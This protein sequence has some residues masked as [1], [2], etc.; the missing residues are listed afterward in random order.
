MDWS[1][2]YSKKNNQKYWFNKKTGESTWV[3]PQELKIHNFRQNKEKDIALLFLTYDNIYFQNIYDDYFNKC[4]VYIH[5]K[6]PEKIIEENRQYIISNIV[7]TEWGKIGIVNA[8]IELLKASY[9]NENNKWFI[10]LSQDTF[11]LFKATTLIDFLGTKRKSMFTVVNVGIDKF[12]ANFN[13]HDVPLY[14]SSQWWCMNREDVRLVL[15]NYMNFKLVGKVQEGAYDEYYF[16][17]LLRGINPEYK[18]TD[19]RF[20]Y[21]D[22]LSSIVTM[23]PSIFNKLT[24][25]DIENIKNAKSFFLRKTFPTFNPTPLFP[26]S[27]L[28]VIFIG[29]DTNQ[30]KLLQNINLDLDIILVSMIDIKLINKNLIDN[31]IKVYSINWRLTNEAILDLVQKYKNIWKKI[32]FVTENFNFENVLNPISKSGPK[33]LENIHYYYFKQTKAPPIN[34]EIFTEITDNDGNKSYVIYQSGGRKV[35]RKSIRKN[36]KNVSKKKRLT[37]R[38]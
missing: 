9:E 18:F 13:G 20:M 1:E 23:H 27:E 7:S 11:P 6:E 8:T 26:S 21:V 25:I 10:L 35:K 31:C 33:K 16:L 38:R 24:T 36:K 4:N 32:Y 17:T 5:P 12:N 19:L 14:K 22:W 29:S 30:L 34:N 3:E 28:F 2:H 37:K 15:E